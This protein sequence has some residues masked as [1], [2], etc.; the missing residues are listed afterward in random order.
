MGDVDPLLRRILGGPAALVPDDDPTDAEFAGAAFV[1]MAAL[2]IG[3]PMAHV[4]AGSTLEAVLLSDV[5]P[6][7]ER[8][9]TPMAPAV[10]LGLG[11]VAGG[12]VAAASAAAVER[13]VAA[14]ARRPVWSP[15]LAGP[16]RAGGC[17]R[18]VA[19]D[20]TVA[21]LGFSVAR[22]GWTRSVECYLDREDGRLTR[23][24]LTFLVGV[25][26]PAHEQQLGV[27]RHLHEAIRAVREDVPA[28]A[29]R[30]LVED[31]LQRSDLHD[32]HRPTPLID[33]FIFAADTLTSPIDDAPAS[34]LVRTVAP[35]LRAWMRGLPREIR[36]LQ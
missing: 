23:T 26:S 9:T 7:F 22:A 13:M 6:S 15:E 2:T 12:R 20:G 33:P 25:G 34:P 10:V 19:A 32:R 35:L 27:R 31:A 28:A 5:I 21:G 16:Q 17:H 1:S 11:S 29:F 8:A 30:T 36:R 4:T 18:L 3:D 14:G 24:Y